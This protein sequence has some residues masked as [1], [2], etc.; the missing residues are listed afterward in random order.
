MRRDDATGGISLEHVDERPVGAWPQRLLRID[1]RLLVAA[2]NGDLVDEVPV[3]GALAAGAMASAP[4]P[5]ARP[6]W[7]AATAEEHGDDASPVPA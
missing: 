7:L 6:M 2:R 1:D 3:G 4:L 5:L